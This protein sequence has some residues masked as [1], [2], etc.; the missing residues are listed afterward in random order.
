[1]AKNQQLADQ[2]TTNIKAGKT[3]E[4]N[5]TTI[6][7]SNEIEVMINLRKF[8]SKASLK[9]KSKYEW[10]K[11]CTNSLS[12]ISIEKKICTFCSP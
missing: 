7:E 6:F 2:N 5:T 12:S 10:N 3:N 11:K 1:M 9:Y 4:Q 8:E